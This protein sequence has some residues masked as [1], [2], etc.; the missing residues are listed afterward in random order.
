MFKKKK[1]NQW[2]KE[3]VLFLFSTICLIDLFLL[4]GMMKNWISIKADCVF[5]VA[6]IVDLKRSNQKYEVYRAVFGD[7]TQHNI[8]IITYFNITICCSL[9][10]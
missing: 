8:I 1:S 9:H 4:P 7:V 6:D 10:M 2:R 5:S 3:N